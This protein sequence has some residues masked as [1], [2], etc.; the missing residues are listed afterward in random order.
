MSEQE[1]DLKM[2][3]VLLCSFHA[4]S[5]NLS[6][7]SQM[8]S[9][10]IEGSKSRPFL[11]SLSLSNNSVILQVRALEYIFWSFLALHFHHLICHP[12]QEDETT[13]TKTSIKSVYMIGSTTASEMNMLQPVHSCQ[14]DVLDTEAHVV[15][16]DA[17]AH[18]LSSNIT[19][20]R[21]L[22]FVCD[23]DFLYYTMT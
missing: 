22:I 7:V 19:N 18:L 20:S 21:L 13:F 23:E 16:S 8:S 10:S 4:L 11:R 12:S 6:S 9:S 17:S 3:E 14:I 5:T 1:R 2:R 15:S